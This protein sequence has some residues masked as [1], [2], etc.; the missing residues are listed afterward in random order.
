MFWDRGSRPNLGLPQDTLGELVTPEGVG[1]RDKSWEGED[2][3][4]RRGTAT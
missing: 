4:L 2:F 1:N 3:Y